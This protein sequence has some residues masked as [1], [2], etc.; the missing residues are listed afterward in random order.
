[1]SLLKMPSS[2]KCDELSESGQ[3]DHDF[4]VSVC[5]KLG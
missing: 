2:W 4:Q 3:L 5:A 1:M